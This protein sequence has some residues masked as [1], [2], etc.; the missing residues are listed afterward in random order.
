[1][2]CWVKA[3]GDVKARISAEDT[4]RAEAKFTTWRG[5]RMLR[6][7]TIRQERPARGA[8]SL[9]RQT[10]LD[11]QPLRFLRAEAAFLARDEALNV[12][13]VAQ[14][15]Q[16]RHHRDGNQRLVADLKQGGTERRRHG[17]DECSQR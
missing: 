2:A 15:E 8:E 5:L 3:T 10:A 11:D 4:P 9:S 14:D 1:M 16:R 6:Q 12:L 13:A 7:Q 17:R